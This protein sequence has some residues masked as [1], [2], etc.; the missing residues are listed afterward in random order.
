M[1]LK[2]KVISISDFIQATYIVTRWGGWCNNLTDKSL[3]VG[4]GLIGDCKGN[5]YS[6]DEDEACTA[7]LYVSGVE[8]TGTLNQIRVTVQINIFTSAR[9]NGENIS[10][11]NRSIALFNEMYKK[12]KNDIRLFTPSKLNKFETLEFMA[13]EY[14]FLTYGECEIPTFDDPIC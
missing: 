4:V 5:T 2:E 9:Q 12:Y 8:S 6:Y 1:T 7:Y 3:P 10:V 13:I 11:Y 14:S